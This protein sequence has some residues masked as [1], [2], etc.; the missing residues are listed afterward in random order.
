MKSFLLLTLFIA[1]SWLSRAGGEFTPISVT[2]QGGS[3]PSVALSRDGRTAYVVWVDLSTDEPA[4]LCARVGWEDGVESSP[5][6]V[7]DI[8]GDVD[9][10]SQASP[11]VSVGPEGNIYVAWQSTFPVEG[12]MFPASNLKFSRSTDGAGSFSPSIYVNDDHEGSPTSHTFHGMDVGPDGSVYI[13]WIDGRRSEGGRR[14]MQGN[15][16]HHGH[17]ARHD[18][19]GPDIRVARSDDQGK[20]FGVSAIVDSIACPCCRTA[21]AVGP[22]GEVYVAWRKLYPDNIRDIAI[23]RSGNRGLS[24]SPAT[25]IYPDEWKIDGCPHHGPSLAVADDGEVHAVWYSGK[26]GAS[27]STHAIS[28]DTGESFPDHRR[29]VFSSGA[30]TSHPAVVLLPDGDAIV[31]AEEWDSGANL[32]RVGLS[33]QEHKELFSAPGSF[34]SLAA[35]HEVCAVAWLR[36]DSVLVC[37]LEM[38]QNVGR[39]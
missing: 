32:I 9:F 22:R 2:G 27:G 31:A 18:A 11:L 36:G 23:A 29:I 25:R 24:F 19:Q 13:S 10:H 4:V 3:N 15:H 37:R 20:S 28:G 39:K 8:A 38:H 30:E 14:E 12:R 5:V 21:V 6:R 35:M 34:P 16:G 26:E 1:V 33:S 17:H 7:N